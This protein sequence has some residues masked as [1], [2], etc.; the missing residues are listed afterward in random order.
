MKIY[1]LGVVNPPS[2]ANDPK[3]TNAGLWI[4]PQKYVIPSGIWTQSP[5]TCTELNFW[6]FY[7]SGIMGQFAGVGLQV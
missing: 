6:F 4:T 5:N 7:V 3:V 1:Y 2:T